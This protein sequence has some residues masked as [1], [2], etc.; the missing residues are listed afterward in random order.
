MNLLKGSEFR[1]H[2]CF[3]ILQFTKTTT[4][5]T[6][7]AS[8]MKLSI[9]LVLAAVATATTY[10]ATI[11]ILVNLIVPVGS[12]TDVLDQASLLDGV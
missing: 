1:G 3:I 8:K 5:T 9:C 7:A 2:S 12:S 11:S 4:A 10:A 6:T